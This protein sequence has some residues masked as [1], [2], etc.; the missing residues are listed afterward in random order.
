MAHVNGHPQGSYLHKP[1]NKPRHT[2]EATAHECPTKFSIKGMHGASRGSLLADRGLGHIVHHHT[3]QP[4]LSFSL[5]RTGAPGA[6][7][8]LEYQWSKDCHPFGDIE[9]SLPQ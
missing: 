4:T 5:I 6:G 9:W 1:S 2:S 7:E 8:G 3:Y